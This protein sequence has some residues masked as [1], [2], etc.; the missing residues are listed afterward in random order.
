MN[1]PNKI[2]I[3]KSLTELS[4]EEAVAIME[5]RMPA[6]KD[7]AVDVAAQAIEGITPGGGRAWAE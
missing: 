6:T 2:D 3:G 7:E 5:G 4:D 1:N